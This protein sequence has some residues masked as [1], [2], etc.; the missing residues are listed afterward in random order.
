MIDFQGGGG[1][2]FTLLDTLQKS[3]IQELD[4]LR[5]EA[6]QRESEADKLVKDTMIG[7]QKWD[8]KTEELVSRL[9]QY[10]D[11]YVGSFV[12]ILCQSV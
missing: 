3:L 6:Q 11:K 1:H 5:V 8:N 4:K 10:R 12:F 9:H 2:K 7:L